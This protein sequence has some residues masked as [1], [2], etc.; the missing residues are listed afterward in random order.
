MQVLDWTDV[1][2]EQVFILSIVGIAEV[3]GSNPTC[4]VLSFRLRNGSSSAL[5]DIILLNFGTCF[6]PFSWLP[7]D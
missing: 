5:G 6:S 7:L 1:G 4:S 2:F 3:V